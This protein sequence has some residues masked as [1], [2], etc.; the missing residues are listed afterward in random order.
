MAAAVGIG[1]GIAVGNRVGGIVGVRAGLVLFRFL[2]LDVVP[3]IIAMSI[4]RI[5]PR[6]YHLKFPLRTSDKSNHELLRG[7][8]DL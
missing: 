2:F 5:T 7:D 6:K 3:A 8:S 4:I 1:D